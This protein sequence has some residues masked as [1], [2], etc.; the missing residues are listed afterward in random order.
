MN[1]T[2]FKFLTSH[3]VPLTSAS[4]SPSPSPGAPAPPALATDTLTSHLSSPLSMLAP[5]APTCLSAACSVRTNA[6]AS[7]GDWRSGRVTTSMRAAPERFRSTRVPPRPAP[8][9]ELEGERD[10]SWKDLAVS[11]CARAVRSESEALTEGGRGRDAPARAGSARGGPQSTR[12][13]R[14]P[15]HSPLPLRPCP[16][17]AASVRARRRPAPRGRTAA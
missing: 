12:P 7:S 10:G 6:A 17:Q 3:L 13:R 8:E 1:R 4:P 2:P 16:E 15:S 9:L 14:C 5:L 11:L